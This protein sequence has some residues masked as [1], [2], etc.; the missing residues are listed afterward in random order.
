[1]LFPSNL[2]EI[3]FFI[4]GEGDTTYSYHTTAV[5]II[6]H[7]NKEEYIRREV[8]RTEKIKKRG[9]EGQNNRVRPGRGLSFENSINH[10]T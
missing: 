3:F 2:D 1:M 9:E 5:Q 6:V 8:L 7:Q 10:S 4:F